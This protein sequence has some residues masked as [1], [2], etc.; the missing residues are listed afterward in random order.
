MKYFSLNIIITITFFLIVQT[1]VTQSIAAQPVATQN[2]L[3]IQYEYAN[4]LFS[5][6]LYFD[7][8]TEFK[9]LKFFDKKGIYNYKAN[10]KIGEAY[11]AGA[12]FNNAIIAFTK[13]KISAENDKEEFDA[14]IEIIRA[15]ILRKTTTRALQLLNQLEKNPIAIGKKDEINYWRGW[16]YMFAGNWQKASNAFASSDK[17]NQL[18]KICDKVVNKEY[19]VTFAKVFSYI[20]PG[21][22]QFYTGHY[23]SGLMSLSWNILWGVTTINA[24]ISKRV[25]DGIVIGNLFWFRFY[26]GNY[27]NAGKFAEENNLKIAN[28]VLNNLQKN[29]KGIKP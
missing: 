23:L 15:N 19:S 1:I 26:R 5:E 27:Q 6:G 21:A 8:I 29:Y 4:N 17:Y 2:Y 13:A 12:K 3:T 16:T 11:K 24:F 25:F 10:I 9:R 7:A 20:L 22:G 18:K 14:E 28:R